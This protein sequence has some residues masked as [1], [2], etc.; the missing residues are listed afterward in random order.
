MTLGD[1]ISAATARLAAC[2]I[3]SSRRDARLLAEL[4]TSLDAAVVAGHP[5]RPLDASTAQTFERLVARRAAREPVSRLAGRREFWSLGFGLSPATLDPRPDSETLVAAALDRIP[6]RAAPWRL[7]DLGTGTG[8][9]LLA[10]LSELPNAWGVGI[11]LVPGAAAQ[12][13]R[14]AA[15]IGLESRAFFAVGRW[16]AAIGR[17]FDVVLANPPYVPSAA[18]AGLA[19]EVARF[20][21]LAALDGGADGLDAYR[22]IAPELP[23][24]LAPSG[25]AVIEV[26]AGQAAQAVEILVRAGLDETARHRDLA[27]VERCLVMARAKKTVG[28]RAGPV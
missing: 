8:C 3:E 25:F 20:E 26:G 16:A 5:E 27:G 10:L 12:A 13:S 28:M 2:G 9:L 15:A 24:L 11:D 21:P 6:D 17:G 19:P 1:A 7:L 23:R 18:I 4:A 22:E 14:N